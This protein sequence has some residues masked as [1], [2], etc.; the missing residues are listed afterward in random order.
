[1]VEQ[2]SL[3]VLIVRGEPFVD[4]SSFLKL[5]GSHLRAKGWRVFQVSGAD[6][7]AGQMYIGQLEGRIR[8]LLAEL[9]VSKKIIW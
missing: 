6:L 8:E 3:R 5:L 2:D 9:N 1:L 7:Q 4:N